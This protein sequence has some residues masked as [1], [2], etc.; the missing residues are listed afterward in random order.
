MSELENFVV[1]YLEEV[2]GLVEPESFGVREVLLPDE[3]AEI[4]NTA[5]Y[6]QI[7]FDDLD[8]P[9]AVRLGYNNPLVETMIVP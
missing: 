1:S 5:V 6:Q 4:W 2:G 3:I 8:N 9:T 7:T